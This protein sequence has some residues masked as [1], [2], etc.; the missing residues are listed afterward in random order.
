MVL[1]SLQTIDIAQVHLEPGLN[2][3]AFQKKGFAEEYGACL[4]YYQKSFNYA[5][6][7][8]SAAG[9]TNSSK[10]QTIV[11]GALV[12]TGYERYMVPMRVSPTVVFYNPLAAGNQARNN[13][14]ATDGVS[15]G[16]AGNVGESMLSWVV[17]GLAA[18]AVNQAILVHWTG[19]AEF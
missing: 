4:R 17:T 3:C 19:D 5:T 7:P 15:T 16:V 8:A 2:V 18:W 6:A 14:T 9:V 12:T 10:I 11:A 13:T 1:N